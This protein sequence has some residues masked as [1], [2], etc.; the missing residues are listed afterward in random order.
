MVRSTNASTCCGSTTSAVDLGGTQPRVLGPQLGSHLRRRRPVVVDEH[1]RLH[2]FAGQPPGQPGADAS[3]GAGHDRHRSCEL[4]P[5]EP[6]RW[7]QVGPA[8][9]PGPAPALRLAGCV[10]RP[11]RRAD[12]RAHAAARRR[13][14]RCSTGCRS[15]APSPGSATAPAWSAGARRRASRSPA[16]TT[17]PLPSAGGRPTSPSS[18]STTPYAVP[19]TGPV[20]F[21][22]FAFDQT[23]GRSV[24]VVP[25]VILGRADGVAWVTVIGDADPALPPVSVPT[26]PGPISWSTRLAERRALA[27]RRTPGGRAHRPRRPRQGR[28]RP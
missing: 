28:P 6:R 16:P 2:A 14:P 18:T 10:H 9:C 5:V 17:S 22:S 3:A 4:H 7:A 27:G 13:L 24:V 23:R 21:A 19:G 11:C 8:G 20:A 26:A 15:M 1:Q 25:E 12:H